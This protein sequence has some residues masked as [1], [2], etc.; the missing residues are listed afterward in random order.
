METFMKVLKQVG[1][2]LKEKVIPNKM[3]FIIECSKTMKE[4][5]VDKAYS[6]KACVYKKR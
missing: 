2:Q 1:F 5:D 6:A 3:F 4:A